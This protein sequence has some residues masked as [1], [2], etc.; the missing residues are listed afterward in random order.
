MDGTN[1]ERN[2][3]LTTQLAELGIPMVIAVNMMDVL[4]KKGDI[5][6]CKALGQ[7]M[8]C[9]VVPVSALKGTGVKEAVERAI[10]L[11]QKRA[12]THPVH[13]FSEQVEGYLEEISARLQGIPENQ[14]RFYAVKLFEN[15]SKITEMMDQAPNVSDVISK[16]EQDMDD[17]AESIITNERYNYISSIIK[18]C[19][20]KKNKTKLTTSDKIDKVVT[21]RWLALPIFAVIMCIVY[22]VSVTTVSWEQ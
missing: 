12:E 1:L 13:T 5:I 3:Y 7:K 21:N 19:Y 22:Y 6:D 14:K 2:L 8:G 16:A 10:N 20:K 15:D 4:Q 9:E 11:V 17:D 18:G